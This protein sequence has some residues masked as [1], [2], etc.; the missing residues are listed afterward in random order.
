M[1]MIIAI[2]PDSDADAVSQALT[3]ASLR[4]TR[5]ASTGGL[6][7]RGN[8]TFLVGLEDEEVPGA[9]E[10]IKANCAPPEPG[11]ESRRGVLFVLKVDDYI[12]L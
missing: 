1:K 5:I 3:Q 8:T 4:V 6:L 7:R 9:L 10:K 12:H 11:A 2:V